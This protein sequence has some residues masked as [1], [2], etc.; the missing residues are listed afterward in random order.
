MKD[1]NIKLNQYVVYAIYIFCL[2]TLINTCSVRS[3]NSE[4]RKLR[5]ELEQTNNKIDSL[6]SRE[7]IQMI[8]NKVMFDFLLYED[9]IDNKKASLSDIRTKIDQIEKELKKTK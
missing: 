6:A 2:L 1:L 4:N 7:E 9:D 5:K 8:S 3:A